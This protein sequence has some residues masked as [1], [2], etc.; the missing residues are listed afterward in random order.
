[1]QGLT[2]GTS[3]FPIQHATLKNPNVILKCISAIHI[4]A[5]L[6]ANPRH[7]HSNRTHTKVTRVSA[8][9]IYLQYLG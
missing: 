7:K 2:I 6:A 3:G 5:T 4:V 9:E 8:S 1:M